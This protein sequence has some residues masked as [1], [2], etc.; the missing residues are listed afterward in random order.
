MVASG[1]RETTVIVV[2]SHIFRIRA[3]AD[4]LWQAV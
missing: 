4:D 2:I 1:H 3:D